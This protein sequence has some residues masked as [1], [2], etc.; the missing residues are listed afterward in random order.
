MSCAIPDHNHAAPYDPVCQKQASEIPS[1][2]AY[3]RENRMSPDGFVRQ[4]D[5]TYNP[6]NEHFL[7]DTCFISEEIRN[8]ARLV[9]SNGQRWV[10]P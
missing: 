4:E 10:C 6:D 1:V 8:G 7:C 5:G 9:G 3:A 2:V